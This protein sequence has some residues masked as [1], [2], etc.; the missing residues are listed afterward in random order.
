MSLPD[1]YYRNRGQQIVTTAVM[2]VSAIYYA[3]ISLLNL[4]EP[5]VLVPAIA[6]GVLSVAIAIRT[7]RMGVVC[8]REH[9]TIRNVSRTV[10]VPWGRIH[11]FE[12]GRLRFFSSTTPVA[13]LFDGQTVPIGSYAM[14][15]ENDRTMRVANK[16]IADLNE[17]LAVRR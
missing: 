11:R 2:V 9:V 3:V 16:L 14:I 12:F 6:I 4:D 10:Q 5:S 15:V 7:S 17:E 1:R 8:R 13:R